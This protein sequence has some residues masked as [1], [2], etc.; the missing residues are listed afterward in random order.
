MGFVIFTTKPNIVPNHRTHCFPKC[1]ALKDDERKNTLAII[2]CKSTIARVWSS[3]MP[4]EQPPPGDRGR[5]RGGADAAARSS[6]P[7]N[8]RQ[9]V[10]NDRISTCSFLMPEVWRLC[11]SYDFKGEAWSFYFER[12]CFHTNTARFGREIKTNSI[13]YFCRAFFVFFEPLFT[14]PS[15]PPSQLV[16]LFILLFLTHIPLILFHHPPFPYYI[17]FDLNDISSECNYNH[18]KCSP[19]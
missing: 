14:H 4:S 9:M 7:S 1:S 15:L 13:L 10:F 19:H 16:F 8:R 5:P 12:K 6:G 11:R 18:T 2:L 3:S 17:F